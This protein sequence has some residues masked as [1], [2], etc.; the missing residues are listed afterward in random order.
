MTQD[1]LAA[2]VLLTVS[3]QDQPSLL[4]PGEVAALTLATLKTR[5][6]QL[7]SHVPVS[8]H[9]PWRMVARLA[10]TPKCP[11][12]RQAEVEGLAAKPALEMQVNVPGW[13]ENG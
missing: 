9:P 7:P 2:L 10:T 8:A 13:L 11:W 12:L 4:T 3:H 5:W 6:S 1:N